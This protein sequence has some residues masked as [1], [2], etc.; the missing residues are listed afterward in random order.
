MKS[1]LLIASLLFAAATIDKAT[2]RAGY[3]VNFVTPK[4]TCDGQTILKF[5]AEELTA[6]TTTPALHCATST[7]AAGSKFL[8]YKMWDTP[9]ICTKM[10]ND[11]GYFFGNGYGDES[12]AFSLV[13]ANTTTQSLY[14]T[15]YADCSAFAG[16][17]TN[18]QASL[19][20]WLKDGTSS[21]AAYL[22]HQ[23]LNQTR[24]AQFN[25]A[26]NG[27]VHFYLDV[28]AA[29]IAATPQFKV[30][31]NVDVRDTPSSSYQVVTY[32]AK[33]AKPTAVS[34]KY[35]S[36][37]PINGDYTTGPLVLDSAGRWYVSF[38][39]QKTPSLISSVNIQVKA[40]FNSMP[41]SGAS[42]LV[43]S[44]LTFLFVIIAS[45]SM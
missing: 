15:A 33:G 24:T 36:G 22:S 4:N 29:Q 6:N 38:F 1:F 31:V 23:L 10:T 42:S 27:W 26:L 30:Y 41:I 13:N 44:T 37:S 17:R 25:I 2:F 7:D 40:G 9:A 20:C 28:T 32:F 34:D 39:S 8:V 11:S 12:D 5:T 16:C 14:F 3:N 18:I 21:S 45:L 19:S 35:P 43:F